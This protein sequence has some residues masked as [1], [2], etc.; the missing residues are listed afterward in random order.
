VTSKDTAAACVAELVAGRG[1]S[2]KSFLYIFVDTFIGG[3][4]VLDSHLRAGISGNAG[5]VGSLPLWLAPA[6]PRKPAQL[7]S[8][9][10]PAE[11]ERTPPRLDS[12]LA[13]DGLG[14]AAPWLPQRC[15]GRGRCRHRAS[16]A[17]RGLPAGPGRRD[18]GRQRRP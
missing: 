4:L 5:A 14:A 3:G 7:L 13:A 18:P 11:P 1:R 2:V 6:A 12:A 10:S 9:A 16:R 17:K 15:S 8:V